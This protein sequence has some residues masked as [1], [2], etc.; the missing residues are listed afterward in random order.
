M[1]IGIITYLFSSDNYGQILQAFALQKFLKLNNFDV[2][3]IDFVSKQKEYF[4]LKTKLRNELS[5]IKWLLFL[6]KK[7]NR[8]GKNIIRYV[9][10]QNKKRKFNKFK[11]ENIQL[12]KNK[13]NRLKDFEND[14]PIYDIY[15]TGSDQVWTTNICD[16]E[17]SSPFFLDFVKNDSKK[18]SYA[19]SMGRQ[20]NDEEIVVFEN[21]LKKFHSISVREETLLKTCLEHGFVKTKLVLDPTLLLDQN[22]YNDILLNTKIKKNKKPYIL[23]YLL[24]LQNQEEAYWE[25]IKIFAE[26]HY[27]D[28]D[29]VYS[30]G[31]FILKEIIPGY[32]GNL[33]TIP[34]WIYSIKNA[35]YVITSSFHGMLFSIIF[36]TPFL[37]IP[38]KG[39]FS[40]GNTRIYDFLKKL[41]LQNRVIE[42]QN[43]ITKIL[44][45]TI[46]WEETNKKLKKLKNESKR[47]LINS[48]LN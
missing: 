1:K 43:E 38:L 13:Y 45:S 4:S 33:K 27:L 15:I 12:S 42:N 30:S 28:M 2:E 29:V 35:N 20:L 48:I 37:V 18:I 10:N 34:E 36:N 3:H 23:Y 7:G 26:S 31:Y 47:F 8:D 44:D 14:P 24:N 22:H 32:R 9:N 5:Y 21:Y 17:V 25:Q 46:N 11:K 40:K 19:A 6:R 39:V 41:D 16:K